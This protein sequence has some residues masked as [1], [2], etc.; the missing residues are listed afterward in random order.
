MGCDRRRSSSRSRPSI[1]DY[2]HAVMQGCRRLSNSRPEIDGLDDLLMA[3]GAAAPRRRDRTGA[4]AI[5]ARLRDTGRRARLP[6]DGATAGARQRPDARARDQPHRHGLLS[7]GR[8]RPQRQPTHGTPARAPRHA[9]LR[10]SVGGR[11]RRPRSL[12][13]VIDLL[14]EAGVM[15]ER[16]RALLEA[17]A[18][19]LEPRDSRAPEAA[20]GV[21]AAPRRDRVPH[22]QS[23]ACVPREY[24]ARGILRS[25]AAVHAPGSVRCGRG[26]CNLGLEHWPARWP[27]ATRGAASPRDST[28]PC[29]PTRSSWITTS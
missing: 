28:R 27:G 3:A 26:I 2:F 13:A 23:R 6:P 25:V 11:I 9:R 7:R 20:D 10:P 4:T 5:A 17:A 14:A 1:T 29:L 22:A 8:R 18:R 21:R 12:D 15:P 19:T 24:A 16:P